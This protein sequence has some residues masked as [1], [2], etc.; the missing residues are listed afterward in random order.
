MKHR[1]LQVCAGALV[2]SVLCGCSGEQQAKGEGG[3]PPGAAQGVP[4]KVAT[5]SDATVSD[6]SGYVATLISR[7]SV[8][9][10]PRV[11]GQVSRIFVRYGDAV[12]AGAP[13]IEID[14][15]VQRANVESLAAAVRTS[16]ANLNSASQTLRSYQATLVS[17][18]SNLRLQKS[19]YDRYVELG[20]QGAVSQLTVDQYRQSFEAAQATVDATKAQIEAQQAQVNAARG[21]IKQAQANLQQ[22]QASLNFYQI[23]A[24]FAGVVGNIPVKVGDYVSTSTSLLSVTQNRP[25]EVTVSIPMEQASR[26]QRGQTVELLD[27]QG[28]VAGESKVF[29]IAPNVDASSQ[30]VLVKALYDNPNNRLKADQLVQV[31]VVWQRQPGV[32]VPTAA[33]SRV[34]DQNF[35]FV[36]Q[37]GQKAD[38]L[39]ARQ[40]P[41]QLGDIQGN[42][43]QV[44]SGLKPN[45]KIVVPGILKLR[46]GVPIVAQP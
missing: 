16:Q 12:N 6:T 31:R 15:S 45:E 24:P 32:L 33:I 2:L 42:A 1:S 28:K 46:D 10:Q 44:K 39:V 26:L 17:N 13:L 8:T 40:R 3:G 34:A 23:Q 30:A 18:Q 5:V 9:M 29:F 20:K 21:S 11:A 7:K 19:T 35:V 27:N 25:L 38:M 14:P 4:V 43:Y 36:A 22:Q 37:P 41:V